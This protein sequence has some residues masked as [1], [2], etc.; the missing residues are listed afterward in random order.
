MPRIV[1]IDYAMRQVLP[2]PRVYSWRAEVEINNRKRLT[3]LGDGTSSLR[4]IGRGSLSQL[5]K[6][7]DGDIEGFES[8]GCRRQR[9]GHR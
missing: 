3:Q 1:W 5:V 4:I 2:K 8:N 7:Q 9:S 6:S